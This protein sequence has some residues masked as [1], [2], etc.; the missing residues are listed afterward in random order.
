M[1]DGLQVTF[2]EMPP[3]EELLRLV[4]EEVERLSSDWP[5]PL[6][7]RVVI[8]RA[9]QRFDAS[10]MVG[11]HAL[12]SLRTEAAGR[13]PEL[14]VRAAFAELRRHFMLGPS[15]SDQAPN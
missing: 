11:L 13:H 4:V 7:C 12:E 10:V 5:D 1:I 14:A 15:Q 9:G 6:E 8:E 2:R 3:Q